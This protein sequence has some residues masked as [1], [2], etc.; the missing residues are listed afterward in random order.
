MLLFSGACRSGKPTTEHPSSFTTTSHKNNG[1]KTENVIIIVMD[2]ARYSETFGDP[3]RKYIPHLNNDIA[4][5]GGICTS[6]YNQGYTYTN[7]G[8]TSLVTGFRQPINNSGERDYPIKPSIFQYWRKATG[9]PREKVW[10]VTTKDKLEIIGNTRDSVWHDQYLPST[11]C[12]F[13]GLGTGYR[14]DATTYARSLQIM[15]KHHPNLMLINFKEPDAS[16]H[17]NDWEGYLQGIEDVDKYIYG[18]FEFIQNDPQY[19]GKTTLFI[20]NDHGRHT[21][22]VR[23]GFINHGC[24]CDGCRHIMLTVYGPDFKAETVV[25]E[26][27]TQIDVPVTAAEL[28][29]FP[30][31]D[32]PGKVM[33]EFFK[34]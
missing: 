14:D 26:K 5:V 1:Y 8:H 2:G 30:I 17:A 25:N 31:Y 12:G 9:A 3:G 23:D 20:T 29:G 13:N 33:W 34:K 18:L 11:D 32:M 7:S 21:E 28:L 4:P 27:Y 24:D 10:V 16:G 19:K 15:K 22:G 6:F